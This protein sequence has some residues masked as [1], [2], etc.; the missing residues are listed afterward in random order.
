V[1]SNVRRQISVRRIPGNRRIKETEIANLRLTNSLK[2]AQISSLSNQLKPHFLFNS[3]NNIRFMIHENAQHAD[4]MII[5]LSEI[6]R[7]SRL[8]TILS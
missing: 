8:V 3:L 7:Y 6:L 1:N 2:E 5:A 4:G